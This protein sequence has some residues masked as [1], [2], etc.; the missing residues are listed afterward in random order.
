MPPSGWSLRNWPNSQA[1]FLGKNKAQKVL[2]LDLKIVQ[3][4]VLIISLLQLDSF[5]NIWWQPKNLLLSLSIT[6]K[7]QNSTF[8]HI[9]ELQ[10]STLLDLMD[11]WETKHI[12]LVQSFMQVNPSWFHF[13]LD[14]DTA[15]FVKTLSAL[16]LVQCSDVSENSDWSNCLIS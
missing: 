12:A 7:F 2:D 13:Y 4:H 6:G 14:H 3:I 5:V 8:G 1:L 10:T 11:N 15:F 9:L 16:W